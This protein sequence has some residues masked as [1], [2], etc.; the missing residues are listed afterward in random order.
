MLNVMAQGEVSSEIKLKKIIDP[1]NVETH[2]INYSMTRSLW[3]G[4]LL[5]RAQNL[6]LI[7][8]IYDL[9][10][11]HAHFHC[12]IKVSLP[13][14]AFIGLKFIVCY[15]YGDSHTFTFVDFCHRYQL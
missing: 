2:S 9:F 3:N 10:Q 15:G 1:Y 14:L 7:K 4:T 5:L 12:C 11:R 6:F 13:L 8:Y